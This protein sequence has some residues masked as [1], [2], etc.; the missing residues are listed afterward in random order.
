MEHNA[1]KVW[2]LAIATASVSFLVAVPA[3]ALA[4]SL[5]GF[6]FDEGQSE[7][8]GTRIFR[9][10]IERLCQVQEARGNR[11]ILVDPSRCA[12]PPPL[13]ATL[14]LWKVVV[15]DDGGTATTTNF[16]AKIDGANVPWGVAQTVSAGAHT[17]SE[18]A[19]PGYTASD[20]GGDCDE[21]GTITLAGGE[22]KT[23]TIT[24]DDLS[25]RLVVDKLT[26]P[27][28]SVREFSILASGTG[29]ITGGGAGVVTDAA[30]KEYEVTAGTYS[31][32]E[33]VPDGWAQVSSTC[34]DV[35][36]GIGEAETCTITNAKLPTLTL[37]KTVTNDDEGVATTTDFQARIDG[38]NVPWGV[39]QTVSVGPHTASE[40]T[41]AGYTASDWG[42]DCAADG[43]ITLAA[44][45]NKTCTVTN[46]DNHVVVEGKLLITE[47]LYDLS[48]A[49]GDPQGSEPA[50]EWV[51]IYN[52]TAATMNLSGF[53]LNDNATTSLDAIPVGIFLAPNTYLVVFGATT[54]ESFWTIPPGA[55]TV[56]L[57]TNIGN[58]LANGGDRVVLKGPGGEEVDSVSWGT[59]TSAFDPSVTLAPDGNSITRTSPTTDTNTA[60]DWVAD[61]TPSPGS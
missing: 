30:N 25:G 18:T 33:A 48:N 32:E 56:V 17:A 3:L 2:R 51:E 53:T 57:A 54:T 39:A 29:T 23:C 58:G 31:V 19:L 24:N 49:E 41:L 27:S 13:A 46:D 40:T 55:M 59:D 16:Q 50:N 11:V 1:R 22:N 8:F 15:N 4:A 21:D 60:A 52:G 45:E 61:P 5:P 26:Q 36:I 37:M 20:W 10:I 9:S 35:E 47:V 12:P 28:G 43:S 38:S 34:E 14:T 44:G 42:D 6:G 7:A